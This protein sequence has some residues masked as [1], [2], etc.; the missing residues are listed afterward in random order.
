[1]ATV[2]KVSN[3]AG[4]PED[5]NRLYFTPMTVDHIKLEQPSVVIGHKVQ[6]T[7]A[8]WQGAPHLAVE[9]VHA[10]QARHVS[11]ADSQ[12][13]QG[14]RDLKCGTKPLFEGTSFLE[15][16][17]RILGGEDAGVGGQPWTVSIQYRNQHFCG[18]SIVA[19]NLVVTAAHCVDPRY[20]KIKSLSVIAGEYDLTKAD[21]QEQKIS[22]SAVRVHPLYDESLFT[23]DLALLELSR[24]IILGSMVQPIC[25]PKVGEEFAFGSKCVAS[26]W[27]RLSESGEMPII[28][29]E[30]SLPI[31]EDNICNSA[32]QNLSL[33]E[34]HETMVCA[35]YPEGGKDTCQGDSGGP[36]VCQRRSGDW[37]LVGSASWGSGCGRRWQY[38]YDGNYDIGSPGIYARTSSMLDFLGISSPVAPVDTERMARRSLDSLQLPF[39]NSIN[40]NTGFPDACGVSPVSIQQLLSRVIGGEEACPHCWP[41]QVALMYEDRFTCGGSII[42]PDWVLTAAHCL[43]PPDPSLYVVIAG[44]H[45]QS[46]NESS[47]QKRNLQ[48][49]A[50][51]EHFTLL[52]LDYDVALIRV[53]EP[54][55]YNSFVHPVCLPTMDK[56]ITPNSLCVVTGWGN[57]EADLD[58]SLSNRLQQLQLPILSNSVCNSSYYHGIIT[59]NM[60]CAG[61]PDPGGKDAC[62][63]D[64]GGPLVCHTASSTS[65]AIQGIVSWGVGCAQ[66]NKPG[67]YAKVQSFLGWIQDTL[68]GKNTHLINKV[69]LEGNL[70]SS[71]LT[72]KSVKTANLINKV[73]PSLVTDKSGCSH[74]V[75]L[76][77]SVSS[78]SSPGYPNGYVAG[79]NCSW[80]FI[81]AS[82]SNVIKVV[83]EDLS[84]AHSV[85]CTTDSL[86]IYQEQKN[87]RTLLGKMCGSLSSKETYVSHGSN[88]GVAFISSREGAYSRRGF[89]LTS[90]IYGE[91]GRQFSDENSDVSNSAQESC[92]DRIETAEGGVITSPGYPEE[93]S[94]NLRC[95]WRIIGP[96]GSVVRLDI[97]HLS[98]RME[99]PGCED[100]LL[101]YEGIGEH[102]TLLSSLCGNV[103]RH[104]L[105]MRGSEM[106]L[107]FTSNSNGTAE[108]FTLRYSTWKLQPDLEEGGVNQTVDGCSGLEFL[109]AGYGELSSPGYPMTYLN[110]LDCWWS[111]SCPSGNRLQL[112]IIDLALE[113]SPNC[114]W[115]TLSVY[116]GADNATRLLATLCGEKSRLSLQS[117]GSSLT[118][119]FHSDVSIGRRGFHLHYTAMNAEA[120]L[121]LRST[122][123]DGRCGIPLIDPIPKSINIPHIVLDK[124]GTARVVGGQ[125]AAWKSWPWLVSLQDKRRKHY[126]GATIIHEKWLLTAAHCKFI[127]GSHRVVVG[128]TDLSER[129]A[130]EVIVKRS[131][132]HELYDVEATPPVY[133]IRLLELERPLVL[134]DAVGVICLPE[135]GELLTEG[136]CLTAGWGM[137]KGF[138]FPKVLQ[139]AKMPVMSKEEC[140]KFWGQDIS[141]GNLCAGA[142]GASSCM[143]DSGG[144][145]ICKM[146]DKYNLVGI[147]SWG[148]N[149]CEPKTPAV[150]TSVSD[151]RDWIAQHIGI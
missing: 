60:F 95:V 133:D 32:L 87:T 22:I 149:T 20:W 3:V 11:L 108:G 30:V 52:N 92:D 25:L 42:S 79:L 109:K 120:R 38:P 146:D 141:E 68:Q 121:P 59:K 123:K 113:D 66:P 53:E 64:S 100:V 77:S 19:Q 107:I 116:D 33:E 34:L 28:L 94:N 124:L 126:C 48:T 5:V 4:S 127:T 138:A 150:Y 62:E 13:S 139:Q 61:F 128:A 8:G 35:G 110:G 130:L 89:V 76:L 147:V 144:P 69:N 96:L 90:W 106:T 40:I 125:A 24:P 51:H 104:A 136:G 44:I 29:Q 36:L 18:G 65:Y 122:K 115:D 27:G 143:A 151:F 49:I 101:V 84:I 112:L 2:Q 55:I 10:K 73:T 67:V 9:H 47:T 23:Y 45:D 97:D 86:S 142:A 63:G 83:I 132:A 43:L 26:G 54:F 119:H 85:N 39:L 129:D 58:E 88:V 1:M 81:S 15:D 102:R 31:I 135:Q 7:S 57:T 148:S 93:Y 111:L 105:K 82:P 12:L 17:S 137:T 114:T 103:S 134:G 80:T 99:Q 37:V 71:L 131:I 98:L 70:G 117:R 50:I 78:I 6:Q 72:D 91:E 75:E 41:W 145:L 140:Q 74:G 21:E 16:N 118:L 56:P 46:L 14:R